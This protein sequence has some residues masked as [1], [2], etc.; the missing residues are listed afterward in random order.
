MFNP[1]LL[2][3]NS[4]C[5]FVIVVVIV[6][7]VAAA[8]VVGKH[9][10]LLFIRVRG[11]TALFVPAGWKGGG[12]SENCSSCSCSSC[13]SAPARLKNKNEGGW[14]PASDPPATR[15]Q[16]VSNL[17]AIRVAKSANFFFALR[18]NAQFCCSHFWRLASNPPAIRVAKSANFFFA[19]CSVLSFALLETHQQPASDPS[20]EIS[21]SF[22]RAL[23]EI[24]SFVICTF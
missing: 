24:F 21:Q 4:C 20:S 7:A 6:V 17:P 10:L 2:L 23:R 5:C 18:A 12:L 9:W 16:P 8:V 14:R 1:Q 19:K 22:F 11:R 13:S 3:E 15:Q